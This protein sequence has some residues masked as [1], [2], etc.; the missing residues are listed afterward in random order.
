MTRK[1]PKIST[2]RDIA[3]DVALERAAKREKAE[4]KKARKEELLQIY[5]N[6]S[7][8]VIPVLVSDRKL[9]RA[10]LNERGETMLR[11]GETGLKRDDVLKGSSG[12]SRAGDLRG[13]GSHNDFYGGES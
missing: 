1:G 9:L 3:N 11:Y 4:L 13:T 2:T 6:T 12:Y 10:G 7:R 8:P 5:D